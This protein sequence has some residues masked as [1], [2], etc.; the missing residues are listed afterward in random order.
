MAH[1]VKAAGNA[2]P[3]LDGSDLRVG[4]AASRFNDVI[5]LRLLE[6][7]H[8]GLRSAA[9]PADGITETWVP[10]AFELPIAAQALIASGRVDAV[11]CIGCVIRG[12]TAHFEH[13]A[14][15][16]ASGI[17]RV[18]LDTGV[19]V[20]FG[21]LTTENL[22]QALARSEPEGG[23]NTGEDAAHAAVEMAA[24]MTRLAAG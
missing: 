9:V 7:V 10:G 19:P 11:V 5:T 13:V 2:P 22:D 12:D 4:I 24:L 8:R 6:G 3:V 1:D 15:Q 21:V 14:T 17:Q 20:L 16:C 18:A 23:H